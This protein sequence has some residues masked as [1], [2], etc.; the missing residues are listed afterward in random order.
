MATWAA[1]GIDSYRT[2]L[3]GYTAAICLDSRMRF[4]EGHTG[5]KR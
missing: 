2:L 5:R 1:I 3:D 4:L